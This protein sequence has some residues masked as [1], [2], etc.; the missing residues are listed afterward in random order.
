VVDN[1]ITTVSTCASV[2]N[3]AYTNLGVITDVNAPV[4]IHDLINI[5]K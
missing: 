1:V 3:N 4:D 5:G 2:L